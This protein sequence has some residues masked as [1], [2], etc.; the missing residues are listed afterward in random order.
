MKV[1]ILAGGLGTR[2]SEETL[3]KPK[4]MVEIGGFPI[5]WHIMKIYSYYGF[6]EFVIALGYKGNIIK[7]YFLN[8]SDRYSDLTIDFT[9]NKITKHQKMKEDWVINLVSTGSDSLTGKRIKKSM[10]FVG[11]ERVLMTYGD[12]L[13]NINLKDLIDFHISNKKLATLTAVRPSARYGEL[14][15]NENLIN[16]FKEK[17]QAG[18]GWIN[19]GFFVLEPEISEYINDDEPFEGAPLEKLSSEGQLGGYKHKGFWQSMDV[20]RDKNLLQN[21]WEQNKAPWKI[22]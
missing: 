10:E 18:E 20:I 2:L 3:L 22:W 13:S 14:S 6:N 15:F 19:G 1:I 17:P 21:L 4:P 16:K 5:L 8:Y 12:G 7:E 11:N 9:N